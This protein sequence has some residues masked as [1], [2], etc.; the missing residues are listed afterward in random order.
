M[1]ISILKKPCLTFFNNHL[2]SPY[3]EH[4]VGAIQLLEMMIWI[5]IYNH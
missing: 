4:L 5:F 3:I 2:K 1:E